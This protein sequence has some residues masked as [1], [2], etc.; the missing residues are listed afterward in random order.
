MVLLDVAVIVNNLL[1]IPVSQ[2]LSDFQNF[3]SWEPALETLNS[4]D[5]DEEE[6][7]KKA[8]QFSAINSD[9]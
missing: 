2:R 6:V 5:D 3:F 8:L 7:Q 4:Q 1:G 9:L